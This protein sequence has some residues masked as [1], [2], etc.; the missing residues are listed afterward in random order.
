MQVTQA[1]RNVSGTS[2][3]A[4]TTRRHLKRAG[5]KAV[6]KKKEPLLA[7]RH[8]ENRLELA[9][10]CRH[11]T[12]DDQKGAMFSGETKIDRLGSDGRRCAWKLPG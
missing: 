10:G 1:R 4:S 12:V 6:I 2:L 8:R 5:L 7:A 9:L 11:W 3:S